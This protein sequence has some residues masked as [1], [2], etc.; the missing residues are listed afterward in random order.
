MSFS[1]PA[2]EDIGPT[3]DQLDGA[4]E[5]A[6]NQQHEPNMD[7]QLL[8]RLLDS[9]NSNDNRQQ[10]RRLMDMMIRHESTAGDLPEQY[11]DNRELDKLNTF[12]HLSGQTKSP[13]AGT[14]GDTS[15]KRDVISVGQCCN[16]METEDVSSS[17]IFPTG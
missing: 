14:V 12:L 13:L 8:T 16:M 9:S 4:L 2:A 3:L 5:P 17:C 7:R 15:D 11:N 10:E 6:N 1:I